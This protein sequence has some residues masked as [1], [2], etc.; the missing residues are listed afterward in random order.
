MSDTSY[1]IKSPDQLIIGDIL[2]AWDTDFVVAN[3][4]PVDDNASY[5]VTFTNGKVNTYPVGMGLKVRK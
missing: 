3:V 2:P 4:I 1:E 5:Q